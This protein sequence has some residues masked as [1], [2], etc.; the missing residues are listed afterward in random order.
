MIAKGSVKIIK[1]VSRYLLFDWFSFDYLLNLFG[2]LRLFLLL[3]L[4]Y[5]DGDVIVISKGCVK[6]VKESIVLNNYWFINND[7]FGRSW[8]I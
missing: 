6:V 2:L 5:E 7:L 4:H 3:F 1:E 8:S